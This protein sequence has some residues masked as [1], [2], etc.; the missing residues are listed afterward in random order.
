[1]QR[2]MKL[3]QGFNIIPTIVAT[4]SAS[5]L[6]S[7]RQPNN[8]LQASSDNESLSWTDFFMKRGTPQKNSSTQEK[9]VNE[10]LQK[11]EYKRDITTEGPVLRFETNHYNA[12]KPIEDRHCE[13]YLTNIDAYFFGMF[14]GHSGWHCSESLR[15][16]LPRYLAVGLLTGEDRQKVDTTKDNLVEYLGNPEDGFLTLQYPDGFSNKQEEYET[17]IKHFIENSNKETI[18]FSQEELIKYSY[19]TLDRDISKEAIPDGKCNEP[20][21]AGLSGAVTVGAYIKDRD[22]YVA[23][24]GTIF[25]FFFVKSL[26]R[27]L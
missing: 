27:K 19:L 13:C 14:D 8:Y 6:Y 16:R 15:V 12:N 7:L 26:N 11:Y 2:S 20:L 23:N 17:G 21:W 10:I 4:V 25:F 9:I 22:L 5:A 3:K 18:G 24:T 1:M